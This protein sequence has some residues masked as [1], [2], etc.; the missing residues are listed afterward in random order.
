MGAAAELVA[1]VG[2]A[3]AD[4]VGLRCGLVEQGG[5]CEGGGIGADGGEVAF[6]VLRVASGWV[7]GR[8]ASR[9]ASV[10]HRGA[11]RGGA[12]RDVGVHAG[13]RDALVAGVDGGAQWDLEV[14]DRSY[15]AGV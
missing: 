10:D 7:D 3:L 5:S 14:L 4:C 13:E 2:V 15:L 12:R 1:G 11:G 9:S 8:S 6:S